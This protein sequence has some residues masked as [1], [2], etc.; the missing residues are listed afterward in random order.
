MTAHK[1]D[2]FIEK[3]EK[4]K[5][6]FLKIFLSFVSIIFLQYLVNRV[7]ATSYGELFFKEHVVLAS[8]FIIGYISLAY[9]FAPLF[10]AP[11]SYASLTIFGVWQNSLYTYIAGL[12]SAGV[13]FW[14]ARKFGR[15]LL[16]TFIGKETLASIDNFVAHSGTGVLI[17][18]RIFGF[19]LFEIITYAFG[20]TKISFKKFFIITALFSIIPNIVIPIIFGAYDFHSIRALVLFMIVLAGIQGVYLLFIQYRW[21]NTR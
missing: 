10:A 3:V 16:Q 1:K 12:L 4:Y 20:L 18:S 6:S 15:K 14:I 19:S 13:G 21:K 7:L 17:V 5:G 9:I 11:V 8:I 2:S